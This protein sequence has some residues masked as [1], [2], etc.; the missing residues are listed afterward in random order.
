MCLDLH[1]WLNVPYDAAV[2][3]TRRRDL[4]VAV[5][6]NSAAYLGV[7]TDEPDLFH[8]T[9]ENSR[10]LRA[11]AAWFSLTAYGAEG[12]REIVE[13]DIAAARRLGALLETIPGVRL[14]APVRL[15]VVCFAVPGGVAAVVEAVR[16]SGEAFLTPTVYNGQPALRAAISNWRTGDEDVDRIFAALRKVLG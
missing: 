10:R 15:N 13:R 16:D 8:L 14:L 4:Q 5:F 11:L 1:K 9:P 2:Q 3:F 6:Q 7:P 12:H